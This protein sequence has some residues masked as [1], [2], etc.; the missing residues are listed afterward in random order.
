[1][2]VFEGINFLSRSPSLSSERLA[3]MHAR[4]S[5]A[6][7]DPYGSAPSQMH[8]VAHTD[9][10]TWQPV[11]NEWQAFWNALGLPKLLALVEASTH[12]AFEDIETDRVQ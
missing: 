3:A 11:E 5:A 9:P 2:R 8:V 12:S 6:G 4:A 7:M 1:M 10:A